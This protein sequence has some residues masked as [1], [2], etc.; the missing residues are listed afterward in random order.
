MRILSSTIRS[1]FT[2]SIPLKALKNSAQKIV[3]VVLAILK[4]F[5]DFLFSRKSVYRSH[6]K[7]ECPKLPS[8]VQANTFSSPPLAKKTVT[9]QIIHRDVK[10]IANG[11]V[12]IITKPISSASIDNSQPPVLKIQPSATQPVFTAKLD[13][14]LNFLIDDVVNYIF[15]HI[16]NPQMALVSKTWAVASHQSYYLLF[17]AFK[18]EQTGLFGFLIQRSMHEY[19]PISSIEEACKQ[20]LKNI[21]AQIMKNAQN[22]EG[23]ED[24]FKA[25]K[26]MGPLSFE[27]LKTIAA[28]TRDQHLI[29]LFE[30]CG[31]QSLD[32][33]DYLNTL[34]TPVK[35]KAA[36][37]RFWMA[38][39]NQAFDAIINLDLAEQ[40]LTELPAE[41]S[42]L[43]NLIELNV[44]NNRLRTLPVSIGLL[45]KLRKI[46]VSNNQFQTSSFD[47]KRPL[48]ISSPSICDH[49][50]LPPTSNQLEEINWHFVISNSKWELAKP[51]SFFEQ[52]QILTDD[53]EKQRK[54]IPFLLPL[55]NTQ[56]YTQKYT[57]KLNVYV[58]KMLSHE[59][60]LT[61]SFLCF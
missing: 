31:Q 10:A 16:A 29:R 4:A 14:P 26:S 42:N 27:R 18:E 51:F 13:D 35:D 38:N 2:P 58:C 46:K 52:I 9:A 12:S 49:L 23:H 30:I 47:F 20:R 7:L 36:A 28:W 44:C 34:D 25:T 61:L 55:K 53:F 40:K 21:Y 41:I 11:P 17:E 24:L 19:P 1:N 3:S 37:I 57:K 39:H 8:N 5:S 56:K 43:N 45:M 22:W 59:G 50:Q 32:A 54:K 33:A 48:L 6:V 15:A 60:D